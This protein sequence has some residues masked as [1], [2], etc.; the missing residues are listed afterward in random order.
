V[1]DRTGVFATTL[2]GSD[3]DD[4]GQYD[5]YDDMSQEE[6]SGREDVDVVDLA[7]T[8][9]DEG[10]EE[11]EEEEGRLQMVSVASAHATQINPVAHAVPV[12]RHPD[13]RGSG[14]SS[15]S[16][17]EVSSR[18][19]SSSSSSD[20]GESETSDLWAEASQ[21]AA[22]PAPK[23]MSAGW[24]VQAVRPAARP[25]HKLENSDSDSDDTD[26]TDDADGGGGVREEAIASGAASG[27]RCEKHNPQPEVSS[28]GASSRAAAQA[29]RARM[30]RSRGQPEATYIGHAPLQSAPLPLLKILDSFYLLVARIDGVWYPPGSFGV[31]AGGE[32]GGSGGGR[33]TAVEP[34]LQYDTVERCVRA[35]VRS[36]GA[37]RL[38]VR[39]KSLSALNVAGAT[40]RYISWFQPLLMAD[41]HGQMASEWEN[42]ATG[43]RRWTCWCELAGFS[44]EDD[45]L[46]SIELKL[47]AEDKLQLG[48]DSPYARE[49]AVLL[50]TGGGGGAAGSWCTMGVVLDVDVK[51]RVMV[52]QAD[53][54]RP[55]PSGCGKVEVVPTCSLTSHRRHFEA[56]H[57]MRHLE[58][59]EVSG[60]PLQLTAYAHTST[61][62]RNNVLTTRILHVFPLTG[63]QGTDEPSTHSNRYP[64]AGGV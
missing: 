9:A 43:A 37:V 18:D 52:V 45:S 46:L 17:S 5:G 23:P 30:Q 25:M 40:D 32:G 56:L 19:G 21:D 28:P 8:S 4:D 36:G 59:T 7:E 54:A 26:D 35:A 20:G 42:L 24:N 13:S 12:E 50:R 10:G 55:L 44:E 29:R 60:N 3:S 27:S 63:L 22:S 49:R 53:P 16:D 33:A 38:G 58:G 61:C 34:P 31:S 62:K 15:S 14:D 11:E 48:A 57:R 6:F 39:A 64:A 47:P 1:Y 51:R 41:L 2:D